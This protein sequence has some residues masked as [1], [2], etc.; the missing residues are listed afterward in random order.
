MHMNLNNGDG[1]VLAL[2]SLNE[3]E[4]ITLCIVHQKKK[5]MCRRKERKM[6]HMV[7]SKKKGECGT[8]VRENND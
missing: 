6:L 2:A 3:S 4:D 7:C 8:K 1:D 5:G